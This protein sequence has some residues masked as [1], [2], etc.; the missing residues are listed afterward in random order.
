MVAKTFGNKIK[1]YNFT[2]AIS[3]L[4]QQKDVEVTGLTCFYF[5]KLEQSETVKCTNLNCNGG[6]SF[7]AFITEFSDNHCC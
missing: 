4:Y 3:I 2:S 7:A 5:Y 6:N 1:L